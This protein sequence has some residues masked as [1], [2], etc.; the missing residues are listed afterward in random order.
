MI[1]V[2]QE[3]KLYIRHDVTSA[4]ST[5]LMPTS[6]RSLSVSERN[7]CR[8][9]SCSSNVPRYLVSPTWRSNV[10]RS[11]G[12][13]ISPGLASLMGPSVAVQGLASLTGPSVAVQGL[14]S[15]IIIIIIFFY[16]S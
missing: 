1:Q 9:T 5:H 10:P 16:K 11:S 3:S 8:S 2:I 13:D 12:V 6:F 15:L 14:A 7:T 4:K